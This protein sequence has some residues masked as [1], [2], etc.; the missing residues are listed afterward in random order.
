MKKLTALLLVLVMCLATLT[1]CSETTSASTDGS[2]PG[3]AAETSA[4]TGEG[5]VYYL[6]FK[7]EQDQQWQ[8]LAT[9]YTNET[10][11]PV[12]VITAANGTYESTL[13]SEMDKKRSSHPVSGQR[14][15]RSVQLE[16]LLL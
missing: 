11:V 10:G 14:P 2:Q 5:S 13:T 16:G 12:T 15:G 7:P 9:A 3:S 6:N 8:D 1:A 4:P